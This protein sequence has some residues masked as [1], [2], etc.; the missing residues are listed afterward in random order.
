MATI[1]VGLRMRRSVVRIFQPVLRYFPNRRNVVDVLELRGVPAGITLRHFCANA[2]S[3]RI[4][5]RRIDD[6]WRHFNHAIW[7]VVTPA[8]AG[9]F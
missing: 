1:H 5:V 9:R 8:V 3:L 2:A 4:G 7:R 6:G